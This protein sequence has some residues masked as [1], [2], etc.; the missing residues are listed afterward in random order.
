MEQEIKSQIAEKK[1]I[2]FDLDKFNQYK[3][4]GF[5][6][7]C[8]KAIKFTFDKLVAFFG[9]VI[10]SP[11]FLLI[12]LIIL[13]SQ[14]GEVFFGH[15]RV[16]QYG[17]AI[18][19]SKFRTMR[20]DNDIRLLPASQ[21][22]E[23]K[24]EYKIKKDPRVFPLG[25]FFR[26]TSLDELP[27]LFQVLT[28]KISIVGPRPLLRE[29]AIDKYGEDVYKLLSI[30]PGITGWWAVNGRNKSTYQSGKRQELELYYV[31]NCSLWLDFKIILLTL[32]KI[33][34]KDGAE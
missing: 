19:L 32:K 12:S 1:Q 34:Q 7:F 2:D 21:R 30:K 10:L 20:E 6:N 22:R 31:D 3:K 33:L 17:K 15:N 29:E 26:K 5:K 9:I 18:K 4:K 27:N 28:G 13:F 14:G 11:L 16:G 24:K 23:Y 25:N 8:Y